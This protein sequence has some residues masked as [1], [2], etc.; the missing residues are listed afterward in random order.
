MID[1][2]KVSKSYLLNNGTRQNVLSELDFSVEEGSSVAI[3]GP[4][5]CGKSTLLNI[6]GTLDQAD[7]GQLLVNK[8][9]LN[10]LTKKELDY[11]R[12][13]SIGFIFQMHHLLP[14]LNVL[15]NVLVPA[16]PFKGVKTETKKRAQHLLSLVGMED[17]M[18]QFPGQLSGGECQRVAV[19]RALINQPKILLADEP[20]GSLDEAAAENISNLLLE[21]TDE[22]NLTLLVV[23]HSMPLATKMKKKYLLEKGKI[24]QNHA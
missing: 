6:I 5:G 21:L 9:N 17:K 22:F 7:S 3:V 24:L 14:Q 8:K 18:M 12:N 1:L 10:A 19:V 13:Q 4:S 2:I 20:T 11:F 23:T 16:I 15:D